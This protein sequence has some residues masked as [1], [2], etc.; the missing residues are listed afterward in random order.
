MRRPSLSTAALALAYAAILLIALVCRFQPSYYAAEMEPF[1]DAFEYSASALSLYQTGS[2]TISVNHVAYPPRYSYG[3]PMLLL[4]AFAI[5]GAEPQ[6]ALYVSLFLSVAMLVTTMLLAHRLSGHLAALAA[7]LVVAVGPAHIQGGQWI[8]SDA[9]GA[10]LILLASY[11]LIVGQDRRQPRRY[12]LVAGFLGGLA[13]ALAISNVIYVAVLGAVSMWWLRREPRLAVRAAL[14]MLLGSLVWI[15]PLLVYNWRTFGSPLKTGY[16]LWTGFF[17][18]T[19]S[20]TLNLSYILTPGWLNKGPGNLEYYLR[21]LLGL[22]ASF[23]GLAFLAAIA[24]GLVY[25]VRSAAPR[26]RRGLALLLLLAL[27]DLA[28]YSMYLFRY[29]RFVLLAGA[30]LAII[31]G[32]G[33]SALTGWV[34]LAVRQRQRQGRYLAR[35]LVCALLLLLVAFTCAGS[36]LDGVRSG[37]VWHTALRGRPWFTY[38]VRYEAIQYLDSQLPNDALIVSG[39][40]PSYLGYYLLRNTARTSMSIARGVEQTTDGPGLAWPVA[41][42]RPDLIAAAIDKGIPV[43]LLDEPE[44]QQWKA[45]LTSLQERFDFRRESVAA[46]GGG[47]R[48]TL[49]RLAEKAR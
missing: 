42:E 17:Y 30:I 1:P 12:W 19:L 25:M 10:C 40:P 48:Y 13:V 35:A 18:N 8:M 45:A 34:V 4:P 43:Y 47:R 23:Y 14:A 2:L 21:S 44:T 11:V 6:K 15:V 32:V 37:Y 26:Q 3:F 36:A 7:G 28:F 38:M 9:A 24:V 41:L 29:P 46:L 22:N 27:A 5:F 20:F 31:G 33:V 49:Y 16:H 39:V